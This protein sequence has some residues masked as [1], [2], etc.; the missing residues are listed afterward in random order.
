MELDCILSW[1]AMTKLHVVNFYFYIL[2]KNCQ[3]KGFGAI[4]H[5]V[6]VYKAQLYEIC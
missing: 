6:H 4:H 5:D 2:K 1:H 3:Q